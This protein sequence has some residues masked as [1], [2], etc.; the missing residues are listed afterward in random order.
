MVSVDLSKWVLFKRHFKVAPFFF[1]L[2]YFF[3]SCFRYFLLVFYSL[4]RFSNCENRILR[5]ISIHYRILIRWHLSEESS[6]WKT[7]LLSQDLRRNDLANLGFGFLQVEAR[8]HLVLL[9]V[10]IAPHPS[11]RIH[12]HV[13][14]RSPAVRG[15]ICRSLHRR[16]LG[17]LRRGLSLL[18]ST[19]NTF[20]PPFLFGNWLVVGLEGWLVLSDLHI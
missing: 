9:A 7:K 17:I 4:I 8:L 13:N 19:E 2:F 10:G 12:R 20:R 16:G 6:K 1:N 18:K 11:R 15:V 14:G 3:P 5:I